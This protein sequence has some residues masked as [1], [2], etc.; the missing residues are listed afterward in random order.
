MKSKFIKSTIILLIGGF[1]SKILGM[2]IKVVLTRVVSTEGIG[3]YML[4]LPTFN[5]FITLCSLGL[6]TAISKMVSEKRTNNK[7]IVLSIIKPIIIYNIILI[8]ILYAISPILS[9]Y[10]LNNN[11][12]YYPL[13][14]IGLTL[15][16][17]CI[18]GIIKGYFFGKEKMIPHTL[19]NITEQL[20]RLFLT[21]FYIPKLLVYG[22]NIAITGVVLINILSEL[23]SIIILMFFLPKNEIITKDDFKRDKAI[24]KDVLNISIPTTGSRLIGS[25]VYFL[26]P[27]ILTYTLVKSGYFNSFITNEYGIINGYVF[28][29]LLMP[30]FFTMAI[31]N[32]LLPTVSNAYSHGHYKYTRS[33]IKQAIFFCL[34]IGIPITIILTLVPEIPLKLIYNTS[35]GLEYIK[36]V[37]PFFI[38]HYIQSPLTSAMQAMGKATSA[39]VGTLCGSLLRTLILIVTGFLKIGLWGLIIATISNFIF[40]TVHHIYYVNKYLKE[41]NNIKFSH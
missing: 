20:V 7:K 26:E 31:S 32:A 41:K 3:L 18:S 9:K 12:T 13:V 14:A 1:I 11:D 4:V 5:L 19:S 15:P 33:K 28:P 39:M 6:P 37:A 40:V 17:I 30:S 36:I 38:L 27:I 21:I 29:L 16:F 24:E 22:L 2:I 34:L 35:E 25:F 23:S 10:L 8:I